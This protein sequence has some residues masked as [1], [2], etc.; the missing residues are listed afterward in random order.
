MKQKLYTIVQK[1][2]DQDHQW[3][4]DQI[5]DIRD[6]NDYWILNYGIIGKN[7]Y[8]GLVRGMVI[9]KPNAN[10]NGDPLSLIVSFPFTR[11]FNQGEI[12]GTNLV[13]VSNSEMIEKLDGT[14]VGVSFPI[15]D[16]KKPIWHTRKMLSTY[17]P[18]LDFTLVSFHGKK[19]K[20]LSLIGDY[21]KKLVFSEEDVIMTYVFEFIHEASYVWTRYSTD[22]YGLYLLAARN[23]NTYDEVSESKL[24]EIARRIGVR[25]PRRWNALSDQDE[26]KALI[27]EVSK[28]T[29]GFE[30][31]VFRDR[32]TGNR[33]KL[34]DKD[35]VR[36]HAMLNKRSYK[37]LVTLVISGE[38]EEILTYFPDTKPKI[39]TIKHKMQNL[40][41]ET[42]AAIKYYRELK[43]D[44][45]SIALQVFKNKN[46]SAKQKF[47]NSFI[48]SYF[49]EP[50]DQKIHN[51]VEKAII[52]LALGNGRVK[53]SSNRL[54]EIMD[55]SDEENINIDENL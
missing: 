7:E 41:T 33:V 12:G 38:E 16:Y 4:K 21:V 50:S 1:L 26:I 13:E 23:M 14:M 31:F 53:G 36:F 48:M 40:I 35:Y 55:L 45:K 15:K 51:A 22:Q 46:L 20:L 18:D 24:D 52:T 43:L 42:V 3:F 17:Q 8:N 34:K 32:I 25:R 5:I 44:Q 6:K 49:Q 29:P 37:H 27:K 19:F 9:R 54:L 2:I 47:I 28:D 10:Y 39:D 11:F 30:G